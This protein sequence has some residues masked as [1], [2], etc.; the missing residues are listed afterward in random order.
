MHVQE[1]EREVKPV[2][3]FILKWKKKTGGGGRERVASPRLSHGKR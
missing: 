2:R 1:R 3:R